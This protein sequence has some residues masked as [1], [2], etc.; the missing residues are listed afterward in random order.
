TGAPTRP[1]RLPASLAC[2][3]GRAGA[4]PGPRL[5][6]ADDRGIPAA[7]RGKLQPLLLSLLRRPGPDRELRAPEFREARGRSGVADPA[8][9][10]HAR[11][12]RVLQHGRVGMSRINL[13]RLQRMRAE[14]SRIAMLTCYDA[15]FAALLEASGVEC[16]LVGDSLGNV[17]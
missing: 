4:R 8:H 16:L 13:P 5:R 15:S 2:N 14:G 3:A 11:R 12:P 1:R 6:A 17:L 9:G 7:A 10:E